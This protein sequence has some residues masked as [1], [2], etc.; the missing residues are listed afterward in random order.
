MLDSPHVVET[1]AQP[2]A[3]IPLAIPRHEIRTVMGPGLAELHAAL[4][5][6]GLVATGPWFTHHLRMDPDVFDF[7]ICLP[8]AATVAAVGRVRPGG[9]TARTIYRGLYEGLEAAWGEFDAW[10]AAQKLRPGPDLW[11]RYLAGPETSP[12]PDDW[13]TQLNRPLLGPM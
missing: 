8:V 1:A 2:M 13:R 9:R 12:N 6:Q 7:E 10:I 4:A 11:E 5:A 3:F